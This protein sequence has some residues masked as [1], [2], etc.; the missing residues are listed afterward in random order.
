MLPPILRPSLL[1]LISTILLACS[2]S[3]DD[4]KNKNTASQAQT[5]SPKTL[6]N[7]SASEE[8]AEWEKSQ[9]KDTH[10][11]PLWTA[12]GAESSIGEI[13]IGQVNDHLQKNQTNLVLDD[14]AISTEGAIPG[15]LFSLSD[16]MQL[17]AEL[18]PDKSQIETLSITL[19]SHLNES[20]QQLLATTLS[21]FTGVSYSTLLTTQK[22][23]IQ[24]VQQSSEPMLNFKIKQVLFQLNKSDQQLTITARNSTPN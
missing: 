19:P 10:T 21:T 23:A 8:E 6:K 15:F 20:D 9:P 12:D 1:L 22:E 5:S 13:F 16:Q 17:I 3:Q 18:N 14:I 4:Q 11:E 7:L 24:K 2:P